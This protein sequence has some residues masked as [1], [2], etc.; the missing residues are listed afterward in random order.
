MKQ[1]QKR[2]NKKITKKCAK[3]SIEYSYTIIK[4]VILTFLSW[5]VCAFFFSSGKPF[6][7]LMP[8]EI[9]W[10]TSINLQSRVKF[11]CHPSV[12]ALLMIPPQD[13]I[14][15]SH[16]ISRSSWLKLQR[17][18]YRNS[19][20]LQVVFFYIDHT[21]PCTLRHI[22]NQK[23]TCLSGGGIRF[24]LYVRRCPL[25]K[26]APPWWRF[27][28]SSSPKTY[29]PDICTRT[30]ELFAWAKVWHHTWSIVWKPTYCT[31]GQLTKVIAKIYHIE[32]SP[33]VTNQISDCDFLCMW[34]VMPPL[35][36]GCGTCKECC[37][38]REVR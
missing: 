29:M 28:Y 10:S 32:L 5:S 9:I 2:E 11:Q 15:E 4:N 17:V 14:W 35:R 33:K 25:S 36:H 31:H 22:A 20:P 38:L 26:L 21:Y 19:H 30:R 24:V 27:R 37:E 3:R 34:H 13:D 8:W 1:W 7:I 6:A 16:R 18:R 12:E 23:S